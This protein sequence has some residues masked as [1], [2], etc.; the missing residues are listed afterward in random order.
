MYTHIRNAG[1]RI[2]W[3]GSGKLSVHSPV[4]DSLLVQLNSGQ[5]HTT[6]MT[7]HYRLALSNDQTGSWDIDTRTSG[8]A[9]INGRLWSTN[10]R[11]NAGS[12]SGATDA[13][14]YSP[15]TSTLGDK[16]VEA[17]FEGLAGYIY[18]VFATTDGIFTNSPT[19]KSIG[20]SGH[21]VNP[22]L[23]LYL[24]PPEAITV[25][26]NI[27]FVT[28]TALEYVSATC[29]DNVLSCQASTQN[30]V[31]PRIVFSTGSTG[32]YSVICDLNGDG[33][34]DFISDSDIR[35]DGISA[36]GQN[37]IVWDGRDGGGNLVNPGNY[38]CKVFVY[39][40]Q[41]HFPLDDVE[42]VY[43][44]LRLFSIAPDGISKLGLY[45]F[46]DDSLVS[47]TP[48]LMPN[49][50]YSIDTP[51]DTLAG[52]FAG[53]YADPFNPNVNSR[54][55]GK[56]QSASKGNNA[57]INTFSLVERNSSDPFIIEIRDATS[58]NCPSNASLSFFPAN[59]TEGDYG[60]T[61]VTV[62]YAFTIPL[63]D[64]LTLSLVTIDGSATGGGDDYV[65]PPA[66][67]VLPKHSMCGDF[68]LEVVADTTSETDEDF[69]LN[70]GI[71]SASFP[72]SI[73]EGAST[74][75][76]IFNDDPLPS[77]GFSTASVSVA[78]GFSGTTTVSLDVIMPWGV[79]SPVNVVFT[80]NPNTATAPSDY[81]ARISESIVI[82]AGATSGTI[83]VDIVG[84]NLREDSPPEEDFSV[85]LDSASGLTFDTRTAVVTIV[86]DDPTDPGIS[87]ALLAS[88]S[89]SET[90]TST[91]VSV[92]LDAPP[93]GEVHIPIS[94]ATNTDE[95]F[96][97]PHW[98]TFGYGNWSTPQTVTLTGI[99]DA[100]DDGDVSYT[101]AVGSAGSPATSSRRAC[102]ASFTNVD[103]DTAAIVVSALNPGTGTTEETGPASTAEFTV[104]LATEPTATVTVPFASSDTGAATVPASIAFTTGDWS[105]PQTVTITGV[106]ENVDDG[107]TPYTISVNAATS[108]DA[109][110]N[111]LAASTTSFSLTHLDDDTAGISVSALS[112]SSTLE[113]NPGA[114]AVFDIVLTSEP[115]ANVEIT[116]ASSDVTEGT[117]SA[118]RALAPLVF[119]PGNWNTPVTVTVAGVNDDFDDGNI[120]YSVTLSAAT[121]ADG[122]YSGMVPSVT[123]QALTNVDDDTAGLVLSAL[124]P[125]PSI[126]EATTSATEFTAVLTASPLTGHTATFAL[127][128]SDVT[129]GTL[130]GASL[131][132]TPAN[133]AVV[134]T[135]TVTAVNDDIDDGNVGFL[136]SIGSGT[137]G[138]PAYSGLAPP[139]GS[140]ALTNVDDDTAGLILSAPSGNTAET[141]TSATLDL[142]LASEPTA[143]VVLDVTSLDTSEGTI[144][145]PSPVTFTSGNWNVVQTV[146]VQGV[147]DAA[148]DGATTYSVR[149]AV[150][151]S[152]DAVYAAKP[153]SSR[154]LVNLDD[155][156]SASV[157]SSS[158]SNDLDEALAPGHT[159]TFT[160]Q[161]SA[162]P[163]APVS[164]GVSSSDTTEGTVTS[165]SPVTFT[166]VTWSTPQTVT[167][168]VADDDDDDGDVAFSVVIADTTSADATWDGLT[169]TDVD[170]TTLDD[171]TAALVLSAPT[172]ASAETDEA[173]S[174]V[175]FTV[176]L[177]ARPASDVTVPVVSSAPSQAAVTSPASLTF[178]SA[179]WNVVQTVTVTGQP[180]DI[181]DGNAAVTIT[182]GPSTGGF[183]GLS[184]TMPI[185]NVDDDTAGF[186]I[187]SPSSLTVAE[188]GTTST[189]TAVLTS[190]PVAGS[191]T[192]P[193]ALA[194]T[195]EASVTPASLVFTTGNWATPQTVTVTG[196]DDDV[197][198]GDV[199]FNVVV[200]PSSAA[201]DPKYNGQAVPGGT[202]ALTCVDDDTA[203]F[204][205]SAASGP[206]PEAGP[207]TATFTVVLTSQPLADV[208]LSASSS[209][210]ATGGSV[211]SGASLVFTTANWATPQTVT[212]TGVDDD[213]DDGDE[214]FSINFAAAVAADGGPGPQLYNGRVVPSVAMVTAD[215]DTAGVLV[216]TPTNGGLVAENGG[217]PTQAEFTVV[218][219]SQPVGSVTLTGLTSSDTSEGTVGVASLVFT[220]GNWATAQTVTVTGVDDDVDDGDVAF[221]VSFSG[222][223]SSDA[224][225][226]ALVAPSIGLTNVDDDTAAIVVVGPQPRLVTSEAGLSDTLTIVLGSR[227]AAGSMFVP[228][229]VSDPIEAS[230]TPT[231]VT[232][233]SAN[234]AMPQTVTVTGKNDLLDDGDKNYGLVFEP[235]VS[236]GADYAGRVPANATWPAFNIAVSAAQFIVVG[237]TG[238]TSEL[239]SGTTFT[240][241][242]G[243]AP[244]A[245][246]RVPLTSSDVS[247]GVI[248]VPAASELNF[249]ATNWAVPQVVTVMGVTDT[250]D[251]GTID[252]EIVMGPAVTTSLDFS[253]YSQSVALQNLDSLPQI[254]TTVL[255]EAVTTE[256]G[257]TVVFVV[258]LLVAPPQDVVMGVTSSDPG[259]GV[260]V[261]AAQ[262]VFESDTWFVPQTVTF[263][264]VPDGVADGDTA[265]S[266]VLLPPS[267]GSAEWMAFDPPD[268]ALVNRDISVVTVTEVSPGVAPALGGT[269]HTVT[270]SNFFP[271]AVVG[272]GLWYVPVENTTFISST[273][274]A[275]VAP[276]QN[277]SVLPFK[278]TVNVTNSDGGFGAKAEALEFTNDCPFEGMFGSGTDCV[279]CP[280]CGYCPGG[281]RRICALEGCWNTGIDSGG[282]WPC[283]PPERCLGGG[284]EAPCLPVCAEGYAGDFCA[285]CAPGFYAL[286][287][288]CLPCE[289][290]AESFPFAVVLT[291]FAFLSLLAII[292]FFGSSRAVHLVG[293]FLLMLQWLMAVGTMAPKRT[294]AMLKIVYLQFGVASFSVELLKPGC[295]VESSS[296]P[297]VF[298]STLSLFCFMGLVIVVGVSGS[299]LW[300]TKVRRKSWADEVRAEFWKRLG[301]SL[302]ILLSVGYFAL[303]T[304]ALRVVHCVETPFGSYMQSDASVK[305]YDSTHSTMMIV[306]IVVLVLVT[307][308]FLLIAF[309]RQY[310][311]HRKQQLAFALAEIQAAQFNNMLNDE[312]AAAEE[313]AVARKYLDEERWWFAFAWLSS[314]LALA[315]ASTILT[316][317][318]VWQFVLCAVVFVAMMVMAL[319]A[320]PF[321][322]HWRNKAAAVFAGFCLLCAAF[323]L[324]ASTE[325]SVETSLL[326]N[327]S[328]GLLALLFAILVF[329]AVLVFRS[330]RR[331]L[332][333]KIKDAGEEGVLA[334]EDGREAVDLDRL[335]TVD[336]PSA[337]SGAAAGGAAAGGIG[338][339]LQHDSPSVANPKGLALSNQLFNDAFGKSTTPAATPAPP[340]MERAVSTPGGIGRDGAGVG[341]AESTKPATA[342]T[343]VTADGDVA[344]PARQGSRRRQPLSARTP[345][346][347]TP[348][349]GAAV[350]PRFTNRQVATHGRQESTTSH[351]SGGSSGQRMRRSRSRSRHGSRKRS[352]SASGT[353]TSLRSGSRGGLIKSSVVSGST[354]LGSD[355]DDD[356]DES[357][358]EVELDV[359]RGHRPGQV[360]LG[361]P[362]R[363]RKRVSVGE[364]G[365]AESR[366]MSIH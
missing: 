317:Y 273:Q 27:P 221:S 31:I 306:A 330:V 61:F 313:A 363:I 234:W 16:I 355:D 96:V 136:V 174:D 76:V 320:Q 79:S 255:G 156:A 346:T 244:I 321:L 126:D 301:R 189:F 220:T 323:N 176:V 4:D 295:L 248:V 231:A 154:S 224:K 259:E 24:A 103:D 52:M 252:Y 247:E 364:A 62:T 157:I 341:D 282:A 67:I 159:A 267:Q 145:S 98:L 291:Y 200:G 339:G 50:E 58:V 105:V 312:A 35:L 197:D 119:T 111:S 365:R 42:T 39:V 228:L 164:I 324:M 132:F 26:E 302:T 84:D 131:V 366:R 344:R 14:F 271:D 185:V 286:G 6:T 358:S 331:N 256:A 357:S 56:F 85:Y 108:A 353:R 86:D 269:S 64:A 190:Q 335:F 130:S 343:A 297:L 161:L 92:V 60:S 83:T 292:S 275:I 315:V 134:Q 258:T 242:L 12:F 59:V 236:T 155:E 37:V 186:V 359:L 202:V 278:A 338:G 241:A 100:I 142:R 140:Y 350:V 192:L 129:E 347:V 319:G 203:G 54:A 264:G 33:G 75:I 257:G 277:V 17:R 188:S 110:Y 19:W 152:A 116:V 268:V 333:Y 281:G 117:L 348:N 81:I 125:G 13:S 196:V 245:D 72:T 104:V 29:H 284:R 32:K 184:A 89:T 225:Y 47:Y 99:D 23:A 318:P 177:A 296:F 303:T 334:D 265:Y 106:A 120:A 191:V 49:G 229:S 8:G 71:A 93:L 124:V 43:P 133:W 82:P 121:S 143:D 153:A 175:T 41:I 55:W 235:A 102:S 94:I 34:Y 146:T 22:A 240:V 272:V 165:V 87:T 113:S 115:A 11:L 18:S 158:I 57:Y 274:L 21:G 212:V 316:E 88:S 198:D 205:V 40:A 325:S 187:S 263:Q 216:S 328:Y 7:G 181:D 30:L 238:P 351:G 332:Y 305:C 97:L 349:A 230:V 322:A 360:S 25:S 329:F 107:D 326:E 65:T 280:S 1:E 206:I 137:S 283:D 38:S 15:F 118:V 66:T 169:T 254:N 44:G 243:S 260:P 69:T 144:T 204:S 101:L 180:D 90:G 53:D 10:W 356:D 218:L 138:D 78:E 342:A 46:W 251:D 149:A 289:S 91:R 222:M 309:V 162:M 128:S 127:A 109:V 285:S 139:F 182:C 141:G 253:G 308:G 337:R 279:P 250:L 28:D 226:A 195:D 173:L 148:I 294:P 219:T 246:V 232:F 290:G 310:R 299:S 179:N 178:T 311:H 151:S 20:K 68:T 327:V 167:L 45:M 207:G 70:I 150:S 214:A 354:S 114:T 147:D 209:S 122:T 249:T 199:T 336:K 304:M 287:D 307:M 51:P 298:Y 166:S 3:S 210:P 217:S 74:V 95:A 314:M 80:T 63:P 223:S 233:T 2:Q 262:L 163:T 73:V 237:P 227:P 172:P 362:S 193:V 168:T 345:A 9:S 340:P 36:I 239:P 270:G 112:T 361:G 266:A 48:V 171:E 293:F 160:L 288:D 276:A 77:I 123:S 183:V 5:Q 261:G 300:Q 135:V 208:T 201:S 211:T 170:V 352:R 215:D 194:A 213:V